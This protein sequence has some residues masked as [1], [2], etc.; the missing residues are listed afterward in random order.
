MDKEKWIDMLGSVLRKY[1]NTKHSTTGVSPNEAVTPSNHFEKWL[2]IIN[3]AKFNR[4]YKTLKVG[5][6][7]RVYQ[8]PKSFKAGYESV[9]SSQIYTITS[10]KDG[11]Y[12]LNGYQKKEFIVGTAC[13]KLMVQTVKIFEF[14]FLET[15]V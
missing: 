7:V 13:L 3:K 6:Q 4:K 10:I 8:K 5:S 12:L 1:N 9:W 11:T 2:N 14:L 15:N